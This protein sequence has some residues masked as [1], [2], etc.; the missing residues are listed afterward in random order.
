M[1]FHA[2]KAQQFHLLL[3]LPRR[4]DAAVVR[5][6][7]PAQRPWPAL[8]Q[9]SRRS[10]AT[11]EVNPNGPVPSP[12]TSTPSSSDPRALPRPQAPRP[13]ASLLPNLCYSRALAAYLIEAKENREHGL[14][15]LKADHPHPSLDFLV[16][17]ARPAVDSA[18]GDPPPPSS[19]LLHEAV[20][21]YP[22]AVEALVKHCGAEKE[23]ER[24]EWKAVLRRLASLYPQSSYVDKL[25]LVHG[26]RCGAL[27]KD[28][29]RLAWL[30]AV[31]EHVV[32]CLERSTQSLSAFHA[33]RAAVFPRGCAVPSAISS[34]Q[35]SQFTDAV[36]R[37]P[38]ELLLAQAQAA[39]DVDGRR[40]AQGGADG[41]DDIAHMSMAELRAALEANG[42]HGLDVHADHPLMALL[43]SLLPWN[44]V[45]PQ[46][47][48]GQPH[49][50]LDG[51][52]PLLQEADPQDVHW[53][54][55]D[56]NV[57]EEDLGEH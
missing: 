45:A 10:T 22:E 50:Q 43:R 29:G 1:D 46:V 5:S 30:R 17:S 8:E 28:E 21:L 7:P 49:G 40:R 56:D 24:A 38:P 57:E 35:R 33:L 20:L 42:L 19:A 13:P 16:A 37:L 31:C 11:G 36:V 4:L 34:L 6:I 27:W 2:I 25:V 14:E 18:D 44:V 15:A 26:E 55:D 3:H 23:L 54:P 12:A 53:L 48:Q 9:W 32:R 52:E 41:E 39:A 47:Q 51:Q